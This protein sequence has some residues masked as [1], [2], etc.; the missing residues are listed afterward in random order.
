LIEKRASFA[1]SFDAE[2]CFEAA[3]GDISQDLFLNTYLPAAFDDETLAENNRSLTHKLSSL[4]LFDSKNQHPTHAGLLILGINP[5]MFI[6]GGYIQYVKWGGMAQDADI[7]ND[8]RFS[9]PL[10]TLLQSLDAFIAQLPVR[11][12]IE[13]STL[14]EQMVYSY[15]PEAL[16]ESLLN[17][18][19]HR[20]YQSNMPIRFYEFTDRIEITNP[21]GLYGQARPENF[22]SINDYR[23][24]VVAESLKV[25]GYVNRFNRGIARVKSVLAKNGSLEPVFMYH[26]PTHFETILYRRADI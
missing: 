18:I 2:P 25:L 7:L 12:P 3:V 8:V 11:K 19:M 20:D 6:P 23:N 22:P 10:I 21:G 14:R 1:Q 26:Q 5:L 4:K 24:P 16:R 9:G 15:P 17:A 13:V